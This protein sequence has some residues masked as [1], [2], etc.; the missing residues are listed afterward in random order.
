MKKTKP[1]DPSFNLAAKFAI[2]FYEEVLRRKFKPT[3]CSV[4]FL[5][6]RFRSNSRDGIGWKSWIISTL[7]AWVYS[8]RKWME[9]EEAAFKAMA[10]RFME[11]NRELF[12]EL[13]F[14]H[15]G[16]KVNV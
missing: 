4:T 14:C 11:E 12:A 3:N 8:S 2:L 7:R 10:D 6:E 13:E 1:V 9:Q 16:S 15:G 5:A